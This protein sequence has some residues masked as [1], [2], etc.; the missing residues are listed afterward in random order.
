MSSSTGSGTQPGVSG[1]SVEVGAAESVGGVVVSGASVGVGAEVVSPIAAPVV[2]APTIVLSDDELQPTTG[3][4][5][6][7]APAKLRFTSRS[8]RFESGRGGVRWPCLLLFHQPDI[9]MIM[10]VA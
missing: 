9:T 7:S 4:S 10:G 5:R 6:K 2:D 8:S 1:A 3:T